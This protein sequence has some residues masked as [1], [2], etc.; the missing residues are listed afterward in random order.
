MGFEQ[1][2][3]LWLRAESNGNEGVVLHAPGLKSSS[4]TT[5]LSLVAYLGHEIFEFFFTPLHGKDKHF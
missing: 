4:L 3:P 5:V 2:R 1:R